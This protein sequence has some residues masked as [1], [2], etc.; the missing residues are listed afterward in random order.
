LCAGVVLVIG[1][2]AQGVRADEA[3]VPVRHP[4]L[5]VLFIEHRA[6]FE[7]YRQIV[8]DPLSV[9]FDESHLDDGRLAGDLE[10]FSDSFAA[11]FTARFIA[12][13]YEPV[14]RPGPGV[15]RVHV[16][17]VDMMVNG[18]TQ[19]Q[20]AWARRFNFPTAP[21]HLTLVAEVSDS[22]SGA[23]LLRVA[24]VGQAGDG[25]DLWRSVRESFHSWAGMLAGV[26][27]ENR[28]APVLA[29]R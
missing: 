17:I 6:R 21:G 29:A 11:G 25:R 18:H 15:L 12:E 24:D 22:H 19:Q 28:R 1:V 8:I 16:E 5:D 23:V 4:G 3:W 7:G 14:E 27:A 10:A 26:L 13:G 2:L 20:L 9:W